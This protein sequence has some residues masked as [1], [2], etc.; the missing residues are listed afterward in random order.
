[1]HGTKFKTKKNLGFCFKQRQCNSDSS[2]MSDYGQPASLSWCQALRAQ[3]LIAYW[4]GSDVVSQAL[5]VFFLSW[6]GPVICPKINSA[7][8][9]NV[10]F[11]STFA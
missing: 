8:A 11:S 1:M 7:Q 3:E 6:A 5:K 2:V 4:R 10:Q 9:A